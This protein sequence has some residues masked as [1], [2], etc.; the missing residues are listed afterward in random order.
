[1]SDIP[2]ELEEALLHR[3]SDAMTSLP[4]GGRTP[5]PERAALVQRIVNEFVR[6][7]KVIAGY[8]LAN[9]PRAAAHKA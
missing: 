5:S 4:D 9:A 2:P 8:E 1:M 7:V 3:L 6:D